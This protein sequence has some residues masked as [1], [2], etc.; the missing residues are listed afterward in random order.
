M[1]ERSELILLYGNSKLRIQRDDD[2]DL[3]Y[4]ISYNKT[5]RNTTRLEMTKWCLK[6]FSPAKNYKAYD[7]PRS[8]PEM[9]RGFLCGPTN[10]CFW[11]QVVLYLTKTVLLYLME[12]EV[13]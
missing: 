10:S 6:K 8:R 1:S 9:A 12:T 5:K 7:Q 4:E 2:R 3:N 11:P 13:Y